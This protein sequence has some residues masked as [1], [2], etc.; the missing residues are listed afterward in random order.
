[1]RGVHDAGRRG[2]LCHEPSLC[3]SSCLPQ[4]GSKSPRMSLHKRS[5]SS[6]APAFILHPSTLILP[7]KPPRP[8]IAP[9]PTHPQPNPSAPASAKPST[10]FSPLKPPRP[11]S[12][13]AQ[14]APRI[15]NPVLTKPLPSR[16]LSRYSL[17]VFT[18][19]PTPTMNQP[20]LHN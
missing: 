18:A 15:E 19:S 8:K 1:M 5:P 16:Y 7:L 10:S 11:K 2:N 17:I 6:S 3:G 14:T 4:N 9:P 20:P 12:H 13:P